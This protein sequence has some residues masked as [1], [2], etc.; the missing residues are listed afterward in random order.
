VKYL[1]WI[2]TVVVLSMAEVASAGN[3]G[4]LQLTEV[5]ANA[6]AVVIAHVVRLGVGVPIVLEIDE[7]IEGDL[8]PRT[9]IEAVVKGRYEN[10]WLRMAELRGLWFLAHEGQD[11]R[12]LPV[13]GGEISFDGLYY[14]LPAGLK[15]PLL[16]ADPSLTGLDR[17]LVRLSA[18]PADNVRDRYRVPQAMY[19]MRSVG[20]TR[21]LQAASDSPDISIREFGLA[22]RIYRGDAKALVEF[23][24]EVEAG[25]LS[26]SREIS[27]VIGANYRNPDPQGLGILSSLV[28]SDTISDGLR[29]DVAMALAAIHSSDCLAAF[30]RM[31]DSPVQIVRYWGALGM[32]LYA[33]DFAMVTSENVVN[34]AYLGRQP[35]EWKFRTQETMSRIPSDETFKADEQK[36]LSFWKRWVSEHVGR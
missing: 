21:M 36:Y 2:S 20:A 24:R 25:R 4:V 31:M 9:V 18:L 12:I 15:S 14:R 16:Q 17:I 8:Q 23:G 1:L 10:G 6:D 35:G 26:D 3:W 19:E 7:S 5:Y 13:E 33:N 28:L 11:W 29:S 34:M 22:G 32:A 27:P 30:S